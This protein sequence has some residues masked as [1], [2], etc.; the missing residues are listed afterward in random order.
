MHFLHLFLDILLGGIILGLLYSLISL[1]L[2]LQFGVTK[3]LNVAHGEFMITA[4][5]FSYVV[6]T[7][8]KMDPFFSL[9]IIIP[10]FFFIGFA[11]EKGLFGRLY[12]RLPLDEVISIS[13]L[14]C[15]GLMFIIQNILLLTFGRS[16][17]SYEY[18][19]Q[20]IDIAGALFTLNRIIVAIAGAVLNIAIYLFLNYTQTGRALRATIT[21]PIG[22]QLVGINISKV[23]SYAFGLGLITSGLAGML[24]S[25][26]YAITPFAGPTY[27]IIALIVII[28]GGFGSMIGSIAGGIILGFTAYMTMRLLSSTLVLVIFYAIFLLILLVRPQGLFRR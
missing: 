26:F 2:N 6:F 25:M 23:R 21:E 24:L 10:L 17:K 5:Y 19:T 20:A 16:E 15:F 13:L 14:I 9:L 7:S 28:L 8:Y 11:L 22:A 12:L 1:G 18:A 27:T 3:I 4:S